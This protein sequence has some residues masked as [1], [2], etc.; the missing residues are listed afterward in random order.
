MADVRTNIRI[1]EALYE[2][3]KQLAEKDFRSINGEIIALLHEAVRRRR[4][5]Q[6]SEEEII[7]PEL[8]LA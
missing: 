6:E 3:I 5:E 2:E 8:A 1:P 7:A 4:T